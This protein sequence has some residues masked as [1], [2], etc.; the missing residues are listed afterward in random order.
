MAWEFDDRVYYAHSLNQRL[1][2]TVN[3]LRR[4]FSLEQLT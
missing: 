1:H 2:D 4:K 3:Q